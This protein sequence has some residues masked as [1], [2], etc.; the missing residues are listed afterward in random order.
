MEPNTIFETYLKQI[1]TRLSGKDYKNAL[2]LCLEMKARL[3]A[4]SPVN[5]ALLGWQ[6]YYHFLC[7]VKLEKDKEALDLFLSKEEQPYILDYTQSNFLTS[8][9]AELACARN[10]IN[11][12]LKLSRQAWSLTFNQPDPVLR[13][14]KAQ[15]ACIYFERLNMNRLNF[16]FARFLTGFGKA[17]DVPALY[18]QGLECLASNYR[19]SASLT[20]AAVLLNS[21]PNVLQLLQNPPK[22]IPKLRITELVEHISKIPSTIT[23]SGK[24]DAAAQH[25]ENNQLMDLLELIKENPLLVNEND[26]N[27]ETLLFKAVA[28]S[29]LS[30]VQMLL[31]LDADLHRSEN[32]VGNSAILRVIE[33]GDVEIATTLLNSGADP[34][35]R[36]N[37]GESALIKAIIED[38]PELLALLLEYGVILDRR[39]ERGHTA[40]MH[41]ITTNKLEMV[42]ALL[43]AGAN[44]T[45]KTLANES[46]LELANKT[47][48]QELITIFD[49]FEKMISKLQGAMGPKE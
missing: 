8:V 21:M 5:P 22:E 13:I 12:T 44:P 6:R 46:M 9:S 10:D 35:S 15:N 34:E 20:I 40:L 3:Y 1:S 41:A 45:V 47:E 39:D 4:N 23:I 27:G 32:V 31:E 42:K 49:D 19:Q 33:T 17:N 25:L 48:N 29:N 2:N 28:Q 36:D 14:Q 26:D 7:L 24:F 18:I 43:T 16:G 37:N 11:L 38:R 30:A